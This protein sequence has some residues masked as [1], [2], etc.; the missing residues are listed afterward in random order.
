MFADFKISIEWAVLVEGF[1][2]QVFS[3]PA[4]SDDSRL[5]AL[6]NLVICLCAV[7]PDL[8]MRVRGSQTY[9]RFR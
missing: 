4:C 5:F 3:G 2:N 8:L 9:T 6:V 7:A 1:E